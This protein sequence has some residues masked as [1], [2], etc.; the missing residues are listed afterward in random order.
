MCLVYV[1]MRLLTQVKQVSLFVYVVSLL[2]APPL[3]E[4]SFLPEDHA[5][6]TRR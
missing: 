1:A 6:S 2:S 3:R 5:W 4:Y